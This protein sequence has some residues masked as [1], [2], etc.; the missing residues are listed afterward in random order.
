M[1]SFV[2]TA[3][4]AILLAVAIEQ[5]SSAYVLSQDYKLNN[6]FNNFTFWTANDPT[7]GYGECD[8]HCGWFKCLSYFSFLAVNYVSKAEATTKK[9]IKLVAATTTTPAQVYM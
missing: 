9:M 8:L 4:L 2:G 1:S 5:A 7:H 6:F 3:F